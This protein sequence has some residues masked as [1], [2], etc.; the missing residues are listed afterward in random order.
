MYNMH[1]I[2]QVNYPYVI[3]VPSHMIYRMDYADLLEK[4]QYKELVFAA[5]HTKSI[6]KSF[7]ST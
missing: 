4:N 5:L 1:A 7:A 2:E 3:L 6:N